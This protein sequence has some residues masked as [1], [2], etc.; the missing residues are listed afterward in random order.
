MMGRNAHAA[1]HL[2]MINQFLIV[3]LIVVSYRENDS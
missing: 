2:R 3:K 1:I